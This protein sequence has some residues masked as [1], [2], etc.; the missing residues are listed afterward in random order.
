MAITPRAQD[1][2]QASIESPPIR[3]RRSHLPPCLD[4]RGAYRP[5]LRG[6]RRE[7][8]TRP[9]RR[10]QVAAPLWVVN[11]GAQ[12]WRMAQ[13]AIPKETRPSWF[14]VHYSLRG[15]TDSESMVA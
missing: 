6:K 2:P 5:A 3:A 15:F 8:R 11:H 9:R 4:P 13:I 12:T 7:V 14:P 10:L 1:A